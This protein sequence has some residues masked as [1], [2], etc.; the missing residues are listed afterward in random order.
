MHS[1]YFSGAAAG[2]EPD[3]V[4][5]R[6]SVCFKHGQ[7]KISSQWYNYLNLSNYINS[8]TV[9]VQPDKSLAPPGGQNKEMHYMAH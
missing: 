3:A 8:L 7:L 2:S 5:Y 4:L 6:S 1:L 9:A